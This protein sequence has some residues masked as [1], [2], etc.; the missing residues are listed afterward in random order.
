[1][2]NASLFYGHLEYFVAIW[3]CCGNLLNFPSFWYIVS[4][5]IWQPCAVTR[6]REQRQKS[7]TSLF[8]DYQEKRHS[9]S[10]SLS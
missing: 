9:Y 2:E 8:R 4:R 7:E 3:Q 1:M 10:I 5:K 6:G